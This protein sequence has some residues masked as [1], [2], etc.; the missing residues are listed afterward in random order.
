MCAC[1]CFVLLA[2]LGGLVYCYMHQLW[3]PGAALIV[4]MAAITFFGKKYSGWRPKPA[5]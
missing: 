2:A 4:V 3:L 1:G 5:D